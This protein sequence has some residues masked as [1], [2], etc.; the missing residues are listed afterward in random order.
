MLEIV[1]PCD[2]WYTT[3]F[4][5]NP[6]VSSKINFENLVKVDNKK[7]KNSPNFFGIFRKILQVGDH[8]TLKFSNTLVLKFPGKF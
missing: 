5:F 4:V 3:E 2:S 7:N 6:V 1:C 8:K